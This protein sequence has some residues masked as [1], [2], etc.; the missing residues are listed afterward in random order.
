MI[1]FALRWF[2]AMRAAPMVP[3]AVLVALVAVAGVVAAGFNPSDNL[4]DFDFYRAA[5]AAVLSDESQLYAVRDGVLNFVYPP[6]A[7]LLFVPAAGFG[8]AVPGAVFSLVSLGALAISCWASVRLA[9]RF[10]FRHARRSGLRSAVLVLPLVGVSF[11][12]MP[13]FQVFYLGQVGLILLALVLADFA[14]PPGSRWRGVGIGLATGIKLTPVIFVGYL[15]FTRRI[16]AAITACATFA[17]T[18][19]IGFVVCPRASWIFWSSGGLLTEARDKA[20]LGLAR[21]ATRVENQSLNGVVA[22]AVHDAFAEHAVWLATVAVTAVAGIACAVLAHRCGEELLGIVLCGVTS[23]LVSPISWLH[24][25]VWVVPALVL[26]VFAALTAT[27]RREAV[28]RWCGAAAYLLCCLPWTVWTVA[29]PGGERIMGRLGL[30]GLAPWS[31]DGRPETSW[32][33]WQSVYGN[34]LA[35][36]GLVSIG[37]AA[38]RLRRHLRPRAQPSGPHAEAGPAKSIGVVRADSG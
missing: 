9:D 14:L 13:V 36:S 26:L 21:V 28:W 16:R 24:H 17:A 3:C 4:S 18:A 25:W 10:D 33:F 2:G 35:L 38:L 22:R 30:V 8:K 11:W 19:G 12:L 20:G 23:T 5:G 32:S 1:A 37:V 29:G 31:L 7:A 27:T 34:G 15:L 6:F